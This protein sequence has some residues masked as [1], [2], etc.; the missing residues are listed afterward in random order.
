[1]TKKNIKIEDS[2]NDIQQIVDQ[3]EQNDVDLKKSLSLYE[4]AIKK[5]KHILEDLE[6]CEEQFSILNQEKESLN[7]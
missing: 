5:S 2:L 3:I 4:D 6:F 1:M 7:L